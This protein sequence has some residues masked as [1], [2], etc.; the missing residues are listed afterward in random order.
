MINFKNKIILVTGCNGFIGKA[1]I[2]TFLKFG[3]KVIGTDFKKDK[4]NSKLYHFIKADLNF[5]SEIKKLHIEIL[6][7]TILNLFLTQIKLNL[8]LRKFTKS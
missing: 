8:K 4:S 2:N 5:K 6:K 3:A 7:K 1:I